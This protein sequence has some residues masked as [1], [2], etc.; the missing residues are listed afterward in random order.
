[1]HH[2]TNYWTIISVILIKNTNPEAKKNMYRLQFKGAIGRLRLDY[3]IGVIYLMNQNRN[4]VLF[5]P[6]NSK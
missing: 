1:M 6:Y 2:E 4:F 5:D 3:D